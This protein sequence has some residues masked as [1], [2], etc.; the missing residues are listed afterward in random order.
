[1]HEVLG[2]TTNL[3]DFLDA[4][5]IPVL[6]VDGDLKVLQANHAAEKTVGKSFAE[7]KDSRVGV[8][9]ACY[10]AE[11]PGGCGHTVRCPGCE[12]RRNLVNTH[13]DG[14]PRY[15]RYTQHQIAGGD[16]LKTVQ[17]RFS[18][19]KVGEVVMLSIEEMKDSQAAS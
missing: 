8:A 17:F 18:T 2:R 3:R 11:Q 5:E 10:N 7:I 4:L 15:S 6:A 19:Q 14:Q 12:L 9:I 13:V 16:V 1:M